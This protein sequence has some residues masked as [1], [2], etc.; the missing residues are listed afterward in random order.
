[1]DPDPIESAIHVAL[2]S[3]YNMVWARAGSNIKVVIATCADAVASQLPPGCYDPATASGPFTSR[4]DLYY[5]HDCKVFTADHLK[6]LT[7]MGPDAGGG[8]SRQMKAICE[9][10]A[11]YFTACPVNGGGN[12][13][14]TEQLYKQVKASQYY[15]D[16]IV[17]WEAFSSNKRFKAAVKEMAS[18]LGHL[19]GE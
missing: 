2:D 7:G 10:L 19:N 15:Q 11:C 9:A 17:A 16:R 5:P 3:I 6:F 12:G 14:T 1:M 13:K 18:E 8:A 4:P